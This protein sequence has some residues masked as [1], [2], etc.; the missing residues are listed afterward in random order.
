[1]P[2]RR[3]SA[4]P[5][6]PGSPFRSL[7]RLAP[8]LAGLAAAGLSCAASA[9]EGTS[10]GT[11]R[12]CADP[13][14][15]PYSNEKQE[16]FENR[17]A[18]MIAADLGIP[19]AYTWWPQSMGFVRATLGARKCDIVMGTASGEQLMQNTNPYYRST[20]ALVH[21]AEGALKPT[22]LADPGLQ[23]ARIGVV[24][25]TPA[26]DLLLRHGLTNIEP[27]QLIIDTRTNQPAR[28]AVEDVASGKTDAAVIWGP[29]AG[30][31]AGRQPTKLTVVPLVG[32]GPESR[33]AFNISMGI[34]PD[35][36]EWKRWLNGWIK[37]N[38]PR[39]DA[40]L[41][42][43]GIPVLDR[44][45]QPVP[46]GAAAA[47]PAASP[48]S[49][50]PAAKPPEPKDYRRSD[51]QAPVPETLAGAA[52]LTPAAAAALADAGGERL[53]LDVLPAKPGPPEGRAGSGAA[54]WVPRP[55]E[56]IPGAVWLP[57]VGHGE[58]TPAQEEYFRRSL[59]RLTGGDKT[60]RLVVFCR[61]DCWMSWNAAKR[62]LEWG[63]SN[64]SWYPDGIEGWTEA[65]RPLA[66]AEPH[67]GGPER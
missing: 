13:N 19:V 36:P 8:I 35:E 49:A 11:L 39:I 43:Y 63:Y 17:L 67:D 30:Y 7:I 59:E 57:D 5:I 28:V 53:F 3:G 24:A 6:P 34:R 29:L 50:S 31:W 45:G 61:R 48:P 20:Y 18:A 52:V 9:V 56:T 37:T 23:G 26:V 1:M 47:F 32:T 10:R 16:G 14:A 51:Y 66:V 27:Y 25:Q 2:A 15:L 12:V 64:V 4:P 65:G 46:R 54:G 38:Q 33:L 22:S 62:A 60:R 44:V 58:P 40:L 41:A 42:E 55:H 21:R